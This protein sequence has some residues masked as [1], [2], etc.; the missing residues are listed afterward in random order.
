MIDLIFIMTYVEKW[1]EWKPLS[2]YTDVMQRCQKQWRESLTSW[3]LE[4]PL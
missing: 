4:I 2:N 3:G 1:I